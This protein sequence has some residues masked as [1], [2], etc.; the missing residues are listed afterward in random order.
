MATLSQLP[1]F[2]RETRNSERQRELTHTPV[3]ANMGFYGPSAYACEVIHIQILSLVLSGG[4]LWPRTRAASALRTR[5][6][7]LLVRVILLRV[8]EGSVDWQTCA[9]DSKIR[10]LTDYLPVGGKS[11][12]YHCNFCSKV[13]TSATSLAV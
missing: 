6:A 13:G 8:A 4:A 2:N 9:A 1:F 10:K 12:Q 7:T 3:P 11:N 5:V